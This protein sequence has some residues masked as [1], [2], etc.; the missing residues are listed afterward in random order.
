MKPMNKCAKFL[1]FF[2]YLVSHCNEPVEL[3]EE[4]QEFY[5]MLRNQQESMADKPLFTETGLQI[6]E[7][8][9]SCDAKNL[10]AKDIAEGMESSSRK[11]GGAMRKLVSDGFVDKFGSNPVVYTLTEKGRNFDIQLYKKEN[12]K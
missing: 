10:K 7:Y 9:Q 8:L 12:E 1:D 5:D 4:V 2:D 11:V 6:L 3:P